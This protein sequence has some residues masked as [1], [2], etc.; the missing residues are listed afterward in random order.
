MFSR[1][2]STHKIGDI[3]QSSC[4]NPYERQRERE[5][6]KKKTTTDIVVGQCH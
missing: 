3:G 6:K 1:I 4:Y 2:G 5:K